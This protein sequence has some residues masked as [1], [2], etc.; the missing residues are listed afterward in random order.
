MTT[1]KRSVD[2]SSLS[3]R[4]VVEK[5]R[6]PTKLWTGYTSQRKQFTELT[7]LEK[8]S[9][10]PVSAFKVQPG[11]AIKLPQPTGVRKSS[12]RVANVS[13]AV[14]LHLV[15]K[16]GAALGDLNLSYRE[17]GLQ[18]FEYCYDDLVGDGE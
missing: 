4:K 9:S 6:A 15:R 3:Y 12:A 11:S 10:T 14:P 17:I 2:A 16:L 7:D 5:L 8:E 13:Y 18:S 1:T